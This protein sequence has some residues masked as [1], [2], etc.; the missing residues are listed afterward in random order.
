MQSA[1]ESTGKEKLAREDIGLQL[2]ALANA[3]VLDALE[4][5]WSC[6]G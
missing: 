6:L 4:T 3:V 1:R 2:A 5:Y